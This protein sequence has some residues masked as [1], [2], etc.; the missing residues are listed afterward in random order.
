M[1]A[2]TIIVTQIIMT[3]LMALSMSGIMLYIAIGSTPDFLTIWM[4][5]FIVAWPI[6]FV[7]TNLM[8][9][10]SNKIARAILRP[11]TKAA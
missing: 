1:N 8:W 6:A 10:I 2:K 11:E 7:M 9:P 5:Q 4:K 3:F